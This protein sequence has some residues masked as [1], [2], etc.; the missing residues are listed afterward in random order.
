MVRMSAHTVHKK[1]RSQRWQRKFSHP[2]VIR[3]GQDP[4]RKAKDIRKYLP[5]Y[6]VPALGASAEKGSTDLVHH[7][8]I[9]LMDVGDMN[10]GLCWGW[11]SQAQVMD[12]D[13]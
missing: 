3:G 7:S 12:H 5:R 1:H 13:S 2:G 10:D 4:G 9:E 6:I 11:E 8:D